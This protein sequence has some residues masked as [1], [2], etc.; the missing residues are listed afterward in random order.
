MAKEVRS[1]QSNAGAIY[2][3]KNE[4]L[5]WDIMNEISLFNDDRLPSLETAIRTM[6]ERNNVFI[7]MLEEAE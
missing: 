4:A 7:S 3:T 2:K 1:W 5:L 6:L